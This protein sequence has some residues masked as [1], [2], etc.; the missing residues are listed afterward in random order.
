MLIDRIV[1]NLG[2]AFEMISLSERG[3]G[4]NPD[5]LVWCLEG[6]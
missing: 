3:A 4:V 2:P 6:S 1:C 5:V